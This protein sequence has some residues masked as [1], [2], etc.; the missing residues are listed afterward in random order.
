MTGVK[1]ISKAMA[2]FQLIR[3]S[4]SPHTVGIS[5]LEELS[6]SG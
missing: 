5:S 6:L 2:G 3:V 4:E 1:S